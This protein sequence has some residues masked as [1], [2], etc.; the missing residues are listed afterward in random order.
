MRTLLNTQQEKS[1]NSNAH[2][3]C[4]C[5]HA[6]ASGGLW[7]PLRAGFVEWRR[8]MKLPN[9]CVRIFVNLEL[10]NENLQCCPDAA[11]G[12]NGRREILVVEIDDE[13]EVSDLACAFPF[14]EREPALILD[15]LDALEV[16][17]G[18]FGWSIIGNGALA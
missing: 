10:G 2:R 16:T 7:T 17:V 13:A 12:T 4:G 18:P 6:L 9:I 1:L 5:D 15:S 11:C 8:W 14:C 3:D